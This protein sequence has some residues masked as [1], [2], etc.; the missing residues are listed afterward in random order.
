M[1]SRHHS[2]VRHAVFANLHKRITLS[3]AGLSYILGV[4]SGL[5]VIKFPSHCSCNYSFSVEHAL[6]CATGGGG[7]LPSVRHNEVRDITASLLS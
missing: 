2:G 6:S 5:S 4:V 7:G 3:T 1:Y